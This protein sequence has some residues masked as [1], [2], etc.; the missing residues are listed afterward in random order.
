MS[1]TVP[2]KSRSRVKLPLTPWAVALALGLLAG[3]ATSL[4][5]STGLPTAPQGDAWMYHQ[6]AR[7]FASG[8]P[9]VFYPGAE[10]STALTSHLYHWFAALCHFIGFTG[11]SAGLGGYL[12]GLLW[13]FGIVTLVWMILRRLEPKVAVLGAV[14]TALS[15]QTLLVCQSQVDMGMYVCLVL[16]LTAAVVCRSSPGMIACATLLPWGRPEGLVLC[17]LLAAVAFAFQTFPE[18]R[19]AVAA[20]IAGVFSGLGVFVFNRLLTG[21]AQFD[22]LNRGGLLDDSPVSGLIRQSLNALLTTGESAFAGLSLSAATLVTLPVLTGGLSG[23]LLMFKS[24][25]ATGRPVVV[26]LSLSVLATLGAS[27]L[28]GYPA[29][30]FF[31]LAS[32]VIALLPAAA[33][34][35]VHRLAT[36]ERFNLARGPAIGTLTAFQALSAVY[37]IAVLHQSTAVVE[38]RQNFARQFDAVYPQGA[39]FAANGGAGLAYPLGG[40]KLVNLA[41]FTSPEMAGGILYAIESLQHDPFKRYDT[42]FVSSDADRGR[43]W[44]IITDGRMSAMLPAWGE[45][46]ALS[47]LRADW[48][49]LD[50]ATEPASLAVSGRTKKLD[51]SDSIDVA[52]LDDEARTNFRVIG[53]PSGKRIQPAIA[54][55]DI[56]EVAISEV[57]RYA[58]EGVEFEAAVV[59]GKDA[60]FALRTSFSALFSLYVNSGNTAA[61]EEFELQNPLRLKVFVN[62]REAGELLMLRGDSDLAEA[63][64]TI[65]GDFLQADR[66][67]IRVAGEHYALQMWIYQ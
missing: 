30:S 39:R 3:L 28:S 27:S 9:Y 13:Q 12:G 62:E 19:G 59:P 42:L 8:D 37:F 20:G 49:R 2:N 60:V 41:G 29:Q 11:E 1:Q 17:L 38:S 44:T 16:G 24:A 25:S 52:F 61:F 7:Q 53:I 14:L 48:S 45:S 40:R 5:S 23:G 56:Q 50:A 4:A 34:L 26:W 36:N 35:G 6:Y 43:T 65:P 51:L 63:A 32:W 67:R 58:P 21:R 57:G 31:R 55:G 46:S 15:G 66:V 64:L 33:V 47:L 10:R 54:R 22:S 18:R